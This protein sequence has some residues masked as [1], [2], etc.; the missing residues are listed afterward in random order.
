MR[1][2]TRLAAVCGAASLCVSASAA[3]AVPEGKLTGAEYRQLSV[4]MTALN[5]SASSKSVNW[6]RARAGCRAVGG[7]TDLLRTQRA[8]CVDS[9]AVL[10][11][12]ASFPAEQR[13]CSAAIKTTTGNTTT[14]TTTTATTTPAE[15]AVIKLII[16]M[17]PRYEGLARHARA[18]DLASIAARKATIARGFH[19]SCL[20]VLAPTPSELQKAKLFA[21]S[22]TRLAADVTL[23]IKV[24]EGKAPS[25][26]FS[27][28]A[29]D[30]DVKRFE[31]SAAAVIDEHGQPTLSACPHQ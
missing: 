20:A 10:D 6:S 17:N 23:L 16:C 29:I 25:S 19:G 7:A 8:S 12:L 18:L 31:S 26:D 5:K 21:S 27:Q 24:T 14:T 13:S 1:A 28:A 3:A 11:A 4:G 15:S 30:D 2:A 9:V 22:T